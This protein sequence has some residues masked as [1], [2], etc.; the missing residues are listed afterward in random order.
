MATS[1][2]LATLYMIVYWQVMHH[3]N[4]LSFSEVYSME[5]LSHVVFDEADTLFDDSF[6]DL[7]KR[8]IRKMMV[9]TPIIILSDY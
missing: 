7:S 1:T 9:C 5:R 4:L 2:T 8:V 6:N 3:C